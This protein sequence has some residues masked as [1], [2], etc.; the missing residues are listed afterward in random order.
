M[1]NKSAWSLIIVI[2]VVIVL[3]NSLF[4]VDETHQVIK[5]QFGKPVGPAITNAGI[6]MKLPFIQ[7]ANSFEKRWLEWDGDANQITTKDKKYIWIDTYARWAIVDPLKFF[8]TMGNETGAQSRLDDIIDGETRLAAARYD[9]IELVRSTNREME[10]TVTEGEKPLD[11]S[12]FQISQGRAAIANQILEKIRQ[13]TPTY[14]IEV[15]DFKVKRINYVDSVRQKVYERMISERKRIAEQYRSEGQGKN[16]EIIGQTQKELQGIESEAYRIS[17][18]IKGKADAEATQI[19]AESYGK[20]P[21]LYQFLKNLETLKSTVSPKQT[22]VT[23]TEAEFFD[24]L[25]NYKK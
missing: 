4:F 7:K 15:V 12:E 2:L 16:A 13:V 14:G 8:E 19:Y 18:E 20:D 11:Q 23:T 6:H 25:K 9:L 24:L 21:D 10:M 5:T 17:E 1:S 22:F 3:G